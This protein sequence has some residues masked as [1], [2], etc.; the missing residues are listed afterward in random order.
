MERIID[1]FKAD[2]EE[3]TAERKAYREKL[4]AI[5]GAN[6]RDTVSYLEQMEANPEEI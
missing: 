2:R 1:I 3:R 4:M 6:Q 5:F